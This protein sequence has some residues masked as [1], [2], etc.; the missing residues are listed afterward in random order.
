[1]YQLIGYWVSK[2]AE[3]KRGKLIMQF[4]LG[5]IIAII[6]I[7][8]ERN[9]KTNTGR[10]TET[11]EK[12]NVNYSHAYQ[13]KY[14]L[15]RNEW[16]EYKKLKQFAEAKELQV[17]PKVR[18]LDIIEPRRGEANYRSLL[19]KVQSKHVDFL[20]TDQDLR[21]KAVV[22][23]DD[24][25]H[26]TKDRKERDEFVDTILTSVGYKVIHAKGITEDT[27]KDIT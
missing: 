27:L 8:I 19:M 6:V 21:I 18:L 16:H 25:S 13:A 12:A 3:N 5:L 10:K 17:C 22:E 9:I 7:A 4:L 2:K 15:T 26:D 20:I 24:G 11:E 14:L 1:M 23:L